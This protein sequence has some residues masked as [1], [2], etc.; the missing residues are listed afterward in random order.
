MGKKK[1][2]K[3][4]SKNEKI[5]NMSRT[6]FMLSFFPKDMLESWFGT[7]DEKLKEFGQFLIEQQE[8]FS[9]DD[10][11]NL[12]YGSNTKYDDK[13]EKLKSKK[14]HS[15]SE[16]L[17][18][19]DDIMDYKYKNDKYKDKVKKRRKKDLGL[20]QYMNSK[21]YS[22]KYL[23]KSKYRKSLKDI[24]K[25]EKE[26]IKVA[27]KLGYITSKDPD[28][29]LKKLISANDMM[30]SALNDSYIQKHFLND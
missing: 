16:S 5:I 21:R 24:A 9:N 29:E 14:C 4:K 18:I 2:K 3:N 26:D 27:R 12:I 17:L 19:H 8:F 30:K 13:I 22:K 11:S 10:I 20:A 6:D 25:S 1:R 23:D 15:I 28:K 7:D